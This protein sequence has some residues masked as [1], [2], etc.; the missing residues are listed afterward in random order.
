MDIPSQ[1]N[2]KEV[3]EKIHQLWLKGDCFNA[4]INPQKKPFSI[5]IPP[6]NI[7]GILHMGHA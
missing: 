5:V 4:D 6:P 1:Y 7:T 2:P 3:E